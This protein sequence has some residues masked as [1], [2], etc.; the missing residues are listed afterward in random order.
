MLKS[1]PAQKVQ[2]EIAKCD[3]TI[4]KLEGGTITALKTAI[5][6]QGIDRLEA[7]RRVPRSCRDRYCCRRH[8]AGND[9][10]SSEL[11]PKSSSVGHARQRPCPANSA[12]ARA[13]LT[14]TP[15]CGFRW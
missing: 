14:A 6:R 8:T 3:A 7:W 2:A 15:S 4:T 5:A 13:D 10:V 9:T 12:Q 1:E 11:L